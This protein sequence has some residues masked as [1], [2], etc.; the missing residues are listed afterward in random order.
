MGEFDANKNCWSGLFSGGNYDWQEG[1]RQVSA[2]IGSMQFHASQS[3]YNGW[4]DVAD[5]IIAR[6]PNK[7]LW[8]GHSN[9]AYAC[10]KGAEKVGKS[11]PEIQHVLI[12][13]DCTLKACPPIGK[14]VIAVQEIYAGLARVKFTDDFRGDYSFRNYEQES[15][16]GVIANPDAQNDAVNF[17]RQWGF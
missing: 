12:I 15:H 9:G 7:V 6:G 8:M 3:G 11:R 2:R 10:T 4:D 14:N 13:W 17:A 5:S 1:L 16:T